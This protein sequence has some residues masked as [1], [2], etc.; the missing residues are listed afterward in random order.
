VRGRYRAPELLFGA[1]MYTPAI[2]VWSAGCIIAELLTGTVL[3]DGANDLDQL[4]KITYAPTRFRH[5]LFVTS[6]AGSLWATSTSSGGQ[7]LRRAF[8]ARFFRALF[9]RAFFGCAMSCG[10]PVGVDEL[11]TFFEFEPVG[12]LKV[13]ARNAFPTTFWRLIF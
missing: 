1:K 13:M 5:C 7:V 9:S 12:A 4:S 11:P 6:F 2:D 3:F 8:F 10:M